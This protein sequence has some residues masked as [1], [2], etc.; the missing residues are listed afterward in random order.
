MSEKGVDVGKGIKSKR[1]V[2]LTIGLLL[3]VS[4]LAFPAQGSEAPDEAAAQAQK[5]A[6]QVVSVEGPEAQTQA[7]AEY[8]TRDRMRRAAAMPS[9]EPVVA[10]GED[11]AAATQGPAGGA[12]SS[13]PDPGAV[14]LAK[15]LD[16]D[17]W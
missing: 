5:L 7:A 11:L 16:P 10:A 6:E 9:P 8:W 17:D 12:D 1:V 13:L 3:A 4:V 2:A 14:A 15:E